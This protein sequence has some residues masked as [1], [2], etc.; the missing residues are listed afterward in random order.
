[1]KPQLALQLYTLRD[2]L[3]QDFAGT[4]AQIAEIGYR[5]VETAFWPAGMTVDQA[6]LLLKQA[7]LTPMAAHIELPLGDQEGPVLAAL[8]TLGCTRAIWHGWPQDP[9][10]SS[11]AGIKRLAERYNRANQLL[12]QHGYSFGL[13]NHWWEFEPVENRFPYQLLLSELDPTIFF[14][15]DTYWIKTA[16]R[17]PAQVIS[18]VGQ[19]AT[20]L[21]IK[22]G[23]AVKGA[24]MT[25]VGD[26]T[27]DFTAILQASA[28]AAGWLVVEL[29]E[30][31][32]D[33]LTAVRRSY[34]YLKG[35]DFVA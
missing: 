28:G 10:Y 23:P 35:H 17:D 27:Q 1:M 32:S 33:M 4:L 16:G 9:D 34:T 22:D 21:H 13:H 8:A 25:A 19:R 2:R 3:G 24:P 12:R 31:A 14:E 5:F 6:A 18:E 15:L 20:V 30:C 29:D 7:G 11:L 26:G